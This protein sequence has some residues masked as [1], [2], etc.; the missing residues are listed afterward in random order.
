MYL[1]H[2]E[3]YEKVN[4]GVFL[5]FIR[6]FDTS[7]FLCRNFKTISQ[8]KKL[9]YQILHRE[10]EIVRSYKAVYNPPR[11]IIFQQ[12]SNNNFTTFPKN[13]VQNLSNHIL[14]IINHGLAQ[15]NF[16]K[17]KL[18]CDTIIVLVLKLHS[19]LL[20]FE[21]PYDELRI[22]S[23][24]QSVIELCLFKVKTLITF[25]FSD[26]KAPLGSN[27]QDKFPRKMSTSVSKFPC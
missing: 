4:K 6:F 25:H 12:F 19:S 23:L 13:K 3:R 5:P 7:S 22:Q 9:S 21:E 18:K 24:L 10:F 14:N 26:Q 8:L 15:I 17:E 1:Y 27:I 20:S 11:S 2:I 16:S